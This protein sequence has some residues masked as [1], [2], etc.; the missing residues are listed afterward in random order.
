[1]APSTSVSLRRRLLEVELGGRADA[2]DAVAEVD[3]VQVQLEDLLLR[4]LLLDA[5]RERELLELAARSSGRTGRAPSVFLTSCWVIVEPPCTTSPAWAFSIRART[6][7]LQFE[8]AVLV[9]L[10]VLDREHGVLRDLAH[11]LQADELP[12][13][14]VD[15]GEL[16]PAVV[17]V[18]RG[19]LGEARDAREV[20]AERRELRV[21]RASRRAPRPG[22]GARSRSR[23]ARSPAG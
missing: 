19:A 21:D 15:R 22:T 20:G 4:V 12:V 10:R 7:E 1:M 8:R 23:A 3:L 16:G 13:V 17:R 2:V 11:V 18:D 5:D 9:E 14:E 6:S